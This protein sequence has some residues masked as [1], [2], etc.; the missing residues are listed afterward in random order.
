MIKPQGIMQTVACAA[1]PYYRALT[2]VHD[3]LYLMLKLAGELNFCGADNNTT[4][5]LMPET[6][7]Q[8]IVIPS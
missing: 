5:I 1:F 2:A 8:A 4:S 7:E 3:Q 6:A